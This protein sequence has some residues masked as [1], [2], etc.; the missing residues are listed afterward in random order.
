MS[1]LKHEV[2][3]F[4]L[5]LDARSGQ[6]TTEELKSRVGAINRLR[7]AVGLAALPTHVFG[8]AAR[9]Q[10]VSSTDRPEVRR[11]ERSFRRRH[12]HRTLA[13]TLTRHRR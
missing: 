10:L 3:E 2:H 13:A 12:R 4:A 1:L 6:L 11:Q 8:Q 7:A 5:I 9:L